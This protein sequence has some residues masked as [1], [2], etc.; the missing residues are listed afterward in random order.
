MGIRYL[1]HFKL[2]FVF[3]QVKPSSFGR[4]DSN[5]F[6]YLLLKIQDRLLHSLMSKNQITRH[7][8]LKNSHR[9]LYPMLD[10]YL[11]DCTSTITLLEPSAKVM[12]AKLEDGEEPYE[13]PFKPSFSQ[14]SYQQQAS[15]WLIRK[16][17]QVLIKQ[18]P[19]C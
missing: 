12:V 3:F 14:L 11:H 4:K 1:I 7:S 16:P 6:N 19:F 18:I 5:S 13:P 10:L 17:P 15:F 8:N 2:S 9:L